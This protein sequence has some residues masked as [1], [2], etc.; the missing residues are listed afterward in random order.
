[1]VGRAAQQGGPATDCHS[2]RDV[3]D[4]E[5]RVASLRVGPGE[6]RGE[7]HIARRVAA[8][9]QGHGPHPQAGD[10]QT[11]AVTRRIIDWHR[12][13][14]QDE[15][16]RPIGMIVHATSHM[17][18]D[19]RY[20]LPLIDQARAVSIEQQSRCHEPRRPCL[21]VNVEAHLAPC[22]LPRGLRL[23]ASAGTLDEYRAGRSEAGAELRVDDAGTVGH[24]P[25]VASRVILGTHL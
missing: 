15:L 18:P 13:S 25:S 5:A 9:R 10:T 14:G 11:A 1:M 23:A 21:I 2:F 12:G 19:C 17:V 7:R 20:E 3:L 16:P 24:R 22:G 4:R 6:E 8:L